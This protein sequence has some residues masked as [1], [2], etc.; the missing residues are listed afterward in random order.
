MHVAF[1]Y[2]LC[3]EL[4]RGLSVT[5]SHLLGIFSDVI[6]CPNFSCGTAIGYIVICARIWAEVPTR[7]PRFGGSLVEF[8]ALIPRKET[9]DLL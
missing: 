7:K 9:V 8:A 6:T 4:T 2:V 5:L 1:R 3:C